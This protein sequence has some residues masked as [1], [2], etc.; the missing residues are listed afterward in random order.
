MAF[1]ATGDKIVYLKIGADGTLSME[2]VDDFKRFHISAE[3]DTLAGD[4]AISAFD[5]ISEDVGDGHFW[6]QADSIVELSGRADDDAWTV[7]FWSMLDK[8]AP[9]GFADPDGRRIK[10]HV[11]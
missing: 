9:Y 2:E 3:M 1:N 7:A 6:L 4:S 8:A 5:D 10:A 11:E